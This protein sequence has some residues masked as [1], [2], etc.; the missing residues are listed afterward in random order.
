MEV[1][2][3]YYQHHHQMKIYIYIAPIQDHVMVVTLHYNQYG[4]ILK[5]TLTRITTDPQMNGH[6]IISIPSL[7]QT[8][9]DLTPIPN[10]EL[11]PAPPSNGIPQQFPPRV[12]M[13]HQD[14]NGPK[15]KKT[16]TPEYLRGKRL[17]TLPAKPSPNRK[18]NIFVPPPLPTS[19]S[20]MTLKTIKDISGNTTTTTTITTTYSFVTGNGND[21]QRTI[22]ADKLQYGPPSQSVPIYMPIGSAETHIKQMYGNNNNNYNNNNNTYNNNYNNRNSNNNQYYTNTQPKQKQKQKQIYN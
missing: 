12:L 13:P 16:I 6:R 14:L 22:S 2:T 15:R 9:A 11:S 7:M 3:P 21:R 4:K 10:A 19:K 5:P 18:P 8:S 20:M 1:K 17:P